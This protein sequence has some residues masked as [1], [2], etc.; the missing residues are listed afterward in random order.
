MNV[1]LPYEGVSDAPVALCNEPKSQRNP[2]ARRCHL[3]ATHDGAHEWD[4]D[5]AA[6][7]PPATIDDQPGTE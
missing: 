2:F 5:P 6:D 1:L 3:P 7:E 4:R